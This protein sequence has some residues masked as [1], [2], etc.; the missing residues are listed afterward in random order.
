MAAAP[1]RAAWGR[2][3]LAGDG[4]EARVL[5]PVGW[6]HAVPPTASARVPRRRKRLRTPSTRARAIA[7]QRRRQR[8]W[9]I[10]PRAHRGF[11]SPRGSRRRF[12]S[13]ASRTAHAQHSGKS[14]LGRLLTCHRRRQE[15]GNRIDTH[16]S[17]LARQIAFKASSGQKLNHHFLSS[18]IIIIFLR[19]II[20]I[21]DKYV[22]FE[23][24]FYVN[25][26]NVLMAIDNR[27]LT[28]E[29]SIQHSLPRCN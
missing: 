29:N 23:D 26:L 18:Y 19:K 28:G 2:G 1:S 24:K 11:N 8:G 15:N 12:P 17:S 4:D 13:P 20:I 14:G 9:R 22:T 25:K 6:G 3:W 21:F 27:S 5:D 10:I 7:P 16:T